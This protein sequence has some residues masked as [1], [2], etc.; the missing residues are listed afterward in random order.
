MTRAG[1]GVRSGRD[2]TL[3]LGPAQVGAGLVL[4]RADL[5]ARW[6]LDLGH[7]A[8][9]PGCTLS[10]AGET[11]V[12]FVEHL[13][14]ALW[15]RGVTDCAVSVDGPEVPL[16]DGSALS[17][18]ELIDCAGL[19]RSGEPVEPLAVAEPTMVLD[20][21][22]A[23]CALP[24]EV[25]YDY[26]LAYDHP[27]IGREFARFRP[28]RDDFD[29]DLAPARTFVTFEEAQ[30]ARQAGLLAAGGEENCVVVYADHLSEEP[31][32]PAAFARHKLVDLI[33]DLYLLGRPIQGRIFAFYTGHRHNH[34]LAAMLAAAEA[35]SAVC[36]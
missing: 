36:R 29:R 34:E 17:L 12:A 20:G 10:G 14:A 7:S 5:G 35:S 2:I 16:F 11:A 18:L 8:P 32:L 3:A 13:M 24:G 1:L 22:R 19:H 23:L 26:A 33:G 15:A 28:G 4:E 27:M 31:S 6:P 25:E 30:G 21:E 9:G